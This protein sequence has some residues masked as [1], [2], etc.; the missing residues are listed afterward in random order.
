MTHP[1]TSGGRALY[2]TLPDELDLA[3]GEAVQF[4]PLFPGAAALET[5]ADGTFDEAVVLAPPGTVERRFVLAQMLRVLR[6]GGELTA[7]APKAKGGSRILAELEGF[8]CAAGS[9]SRRHFRILETRRPDAPSGLGAAISAG[10]PYRDE[11]TGLWTQAGVFSADR[12]DPGSR[13]LL[14]RLPPLKGRG[15][16]LGCGLGVL[17]QGV[18]AH[19]SVSS[20]VCVDID[21]RAVEAARRNLADPRAEFLWADLRLV[22][23]PALAGLDFIVS[24][25]PFHDGG[26]ENR[27]L[28]QVF[29]RRAASMLRKGGSAFFVAN[30]HLP[31]ERVLGEAFARV[32]PI[33]EDAGFKL[34]EARA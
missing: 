32:Q 24:N 28:G 12:I 10:Q 25:P 23:T 16:D 11:A 30:R 27:S 3:G 1:S 21:R 14:E 7:L 19:P 2:G 6:P 34:F 17:G 31:Y 13:L 26:A 29:I 9:S 20:L 5:A 18:L 4:S 8:G 22:S 15:A 33:G